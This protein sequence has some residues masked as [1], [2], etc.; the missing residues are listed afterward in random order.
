M[1]LAWPTTTKRNTG[2]LRRFS[3]LTGCPDKPTSTRCQLILGYVSGEDEGAVEGPE[4]MCHTQQAQLVFTC[5]RDT[6]FF[7]L[8]IVII[9]DTFAYLML[10][11]PR[12]KWSRWPAAQYINLF[13][14]WLC[15]IKTMNN[16]AGHDARGKMAARVHAAIRCIFGQPARGSILLG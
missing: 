6:A 9:P 15:P 16:S 2:S 11:W 10:V 12:P 4:G 3:I 14:S 8:R 13:S 7:R 5:S 1:P